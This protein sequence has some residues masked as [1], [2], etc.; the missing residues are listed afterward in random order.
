MPTIL[1]KLPS[2]S[3]PD[4]GFVLAYDSLIPD[5][6]DFSSYGFGMK[7]VKDT[8][9]WLGSVETISLP[10]YLSKQVLQHVVSSLTLTR[11]AVPSSEQTFD[12]GCLVLADPKNMEATATA[13]ILAEF[14]AREM[15][16]T[17]VPVVLS[18]EDRVGPT[19]VDVLHLILVC[20]AGCLESSK[21]AEWLLQARFISTCFISPVISDDRFELP[22]KM[23]YQSL[24]QHPYADT[25]DLGAYVHVLQAVFLEIALPFSPQ[26]CSEAELRLRAKQISARLLPGAAVRNLSS[27]MVMLASNAEL[28]EVSLALAADGRSSLALL[29]SGLSGAM[30]SVG[31]GTTGAR[32]EVQTRAASE[33]IFQMLMNLSS[34]AWSPRNFRTSRHPVMQWP[35]NRRLLR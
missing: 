5:L 18:A 27:R 26:S 29:K 17:S 28:I 14:T 20:T 24:A 31:K 22:S 9:R 32:A 2:F 34:S 33:R 13:Y 19:K 30:R 7:E 1:L 10:S 4:E 8:L 3:K 23:S 11:A 16:H 35:W 21:I 25:L 12:N 6:C 15:M